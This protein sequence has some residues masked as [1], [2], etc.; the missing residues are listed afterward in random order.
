MLG[1]MAQPTKNTFLFYDLETSGFDYKSQ[2]IMQFAGQRTDMDLQPIGDA[3]NLL[4]TMTEDVLPDPGAIM[5]TGIT[6]QQTVA[7]GMSEAEFSKLLHA[8]VCTPGTI[9]V[10]YNNVRFDDEFLRFTFYRNFYDPYEWCWL[11]NRSRWDLLDVVRFT[12]A[13]RPEGIKWPSDKSGKPVNKL[14]LLAK[15]NNLLHTKAHDALSDVEALIALTKLIRDKQPKLYDYLLKMRDAKEVAEIVGINDPKPFVY[16]SGRYNGEFQATTVAFALSRHPVKNKAALVYDLRH[17]PTPYLNA[18]PLQ[19]A[20]SMFGKTAG[21]DTPRLPVKELA[22]N[23]CP[24]VGPAGV[25]ADQS[26]QERLGL[27]MDIIEKH[28]NILRRNRQF[29]DAVTEAYNLRPDYETAADVDGQL[30]DGFFGDSDKKA[31]EAIR[32]ADPETLAK[33]NPKFV[34]GRLEELFIRYK[35]RNFPKTLTSEDRAAWED[36]RKKR[37][38]RDL[39]GFTKELQ[40]A[41][42]ESSA[43]DKEFL[44]QELTLWAESIAPSDE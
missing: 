25:V 19:L 24:A 18:T 27:D 23:K 31:I 2:R 6:P 38:M 39:P 40:K 4:V 10:G 43:H 11:D 32:N 41:G 9:M 44:L 30:Y 20:E 35:A 16:T 42:G 3:F 13:L 1:D 5:V 8:E 7:E 33:F 12:R 28:A 21:T 22:F 15:E 37:F 34:D 36:Y 29:T 14:E 26:I 17:D